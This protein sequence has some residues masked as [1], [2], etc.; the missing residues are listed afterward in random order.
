MRTREEFLREQA[1]SSIKNKEGNQRQLDDILVTVTA[2]AFGISI[3]F[4]TAVSDKLIYE[5]K[6]YA[7]WW[8]LAIS[9]ILQII[10]FC[11]AIVKAQI[12]YRFYDGGL[13]SKYVI[14]EDCYNT[15]QRKWKWTN[16]M[17]DALNGICVALTITAI[18]MLTMFGVVNMSHIKGL[19]DA[20]AAVRAKGIQEERPEESRA[21]NINFMI[22][23]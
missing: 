9:L 1:D 17:I 19:K 7:I 8:I 12:D 20:E 4:F 2:G 14:N 18:V 22:Q 21:I 10:N 16:W 11:L 23:K 13:R 5:E 6:L 15:H 3:A